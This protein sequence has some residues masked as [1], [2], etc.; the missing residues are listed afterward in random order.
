[1][2]ILKKIVFG[3]L[4]VVVALLLIAFVL[5][6]QSHVE[7]RVTITAT[8]A[9]VFAVLR[10]FQQFNQ[11][12]P[13]AAIDSNTQYTYSGP[14]GDVGSKY[15]WRGNNSVGAGSQ[16]ITALTPDQEI[17]MHLI[18]E[19]QG[20]AQVAFRL[21]DEQG[22]TNVTW[23]FDSEHGM[24]PLNRWFGLM[25]DGM[26][27]GDYEKGLSQLKTYVEGLPDKVDV[28]PV[29]EPRLDPQ[30]EESLSADAV[31][32]A[33]EPPTDEDSTVSENEQ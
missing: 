22:Q 3:L 4:I 31:E 20:D 32:D 2:S 13:W 10:D 11:W 18:F 19:G 9:K 8:P 21:N 24:N 29:E 25:L 14:S 7:R 33:G 17:K 28:E 12:S 26:I 6:A 5:P 27:G 1:M 16:E 23:T 30:T 15:E